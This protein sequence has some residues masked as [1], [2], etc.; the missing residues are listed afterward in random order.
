MNYM[1]FIWAI[2]DKVWPTETKKW[3]F[4]LMSTSLV[5]SCNKEKRKFIWFLSTFY[6]WSFWIVPSSAEFNNGKNIF[7]LKKEDIWIKSN[8]IKNYSH[9]EDPNNRDNFKRERPKDKYA[10]I[11]K[12]IPIQISPKKTQTNPLSGA[13]QKKERI[14]N[15]IGFICFDPL[16]PPPNKDIGVGKFKNK[17]VKCS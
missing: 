7:F 6:Y 3:I 11:L 9:F 8:V 4:V 13:I 5:M 12:K 16:P 10:Y 17:L 1:D 14:Y 2:R 15:D